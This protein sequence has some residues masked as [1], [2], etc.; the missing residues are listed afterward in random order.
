MWLSIL[1]TILRYQ[2]IREKKKACNS[3]IK[4]VVFNEEKCTEFKCCL[5]KEQFLKDS[6]YIFPL[7][8]QSSFSSKYL[9][10]CQMF[11]TG[12]ITSKL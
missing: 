7:V 8:V 9:I 1:S 12:H 10:P 6:I 5:Y 4:F 11:H 3:P 2:K